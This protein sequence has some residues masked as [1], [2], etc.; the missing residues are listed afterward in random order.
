MPEREILNGADPC[1]LAGRWGVRLDVMEKVV[2]AANLTTHEIGRD[3]LI[4]SGARSREEQAA[5]ERDGRPTARD[6][7]STHRSCP[8]TG[9][10]ISLGI[11]GFGVVRIMKVIWGRNAFMSGLRV[12]GGSQL[13]ESGVLHIDWNHVD[14]GPRA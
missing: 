8:A 5:L 4:I 10:D 13:D 1:T 3:V 12:G 7:R 2:A 14:V 11:G 6:G 9:V